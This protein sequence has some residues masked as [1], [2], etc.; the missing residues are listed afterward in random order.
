MNKDQTINLVQTILMWFSGIAIAHGFGTAANWEGVAGIVGSVVTFLFT[1][2]W[3]KTTTAPSKNTTA[4]LMLFLACAGALAV[5]GCASSL[6]PGGA[7]DPVTVSTNT[8]GTVSTNDVP[9]MQLY[10]ADNAYK[11]AYDIVDGVLLWEYNNRASLS[12]SWPQ[13]KPALDQIRPTVYQIELRWAT[14]RLAYLQNPTPANLN[15]LQGV[16]KELQ[17]LAPV[18]QGM[19]QP[20]MPSTNTFHAPA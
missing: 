5:S 15:T 1:H 19:I 14:A 20:A 2:N 16:L 12:Q 8:T 7:Y 18:F 10:V 4:P 17:N 3:N 9:D 6:A 13:L 11:V